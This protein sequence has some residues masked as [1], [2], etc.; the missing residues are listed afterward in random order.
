ME[1]E[2]DPDVIPSQYGKRSGSRK[3][4]FFCSYIVSLFRNYCRT[5]ETQT[6]FFIVFSAL[7]PFNFNQI[8]TH[9]F[10]TFTFMSL[11]PLLSVFSRNRNQSHQHDNNTTNGQ[12]KHL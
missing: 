11:S 4:S 3:E 6:E 1:D 2:R 5:L 9:T 12:S 10:L 8:F 7:C